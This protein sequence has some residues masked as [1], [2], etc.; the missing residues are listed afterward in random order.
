MEFSNK[1][2]F[3]KCDQ[4]RSF[5]QIWSHLLKKSF[6]ESFM[7]CA[8]YLDLIAGMFHK[9]FSTVSEWFYDN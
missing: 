5:L 3:S 7:F 2:F 9:D 6:M 4:I 8:V 1:Y